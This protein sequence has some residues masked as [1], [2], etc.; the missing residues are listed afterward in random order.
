MTLEGEKNRIDQ[1]LLLECYADDLIDFIAVFLFFLMFEKEL[2]ELVPAD[3]IVASRVCADRVAGNGGNGDHVVDST[4]TGVG[5]IIEN[6]PS[7]QTRQVSRDVECIVLVMLLSEKVLLE[8]QFGGEL[9]EQILQIASTVEIERFEQFHEFGKVH[10]ILVDHPGRGRRIAH[11]RG[12][13]RTARQGT[14]G[15]A[16]VRQS[17]RRSSVGQG[18]IRQTEPRSNRTHQGVRGF[19]TFTDGDNAPLPSSQFEMSYLDYF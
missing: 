2:S 7:D 4:E 8:S 14:S 13:R 3:Q 6:V 18:I 10:Q 19:R 5:D 1:N 12:R 15:Q 9:L 17:V 16:F 11:R